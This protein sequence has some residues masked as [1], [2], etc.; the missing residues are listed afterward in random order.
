MPSYMIT[1]TATKSDFIFTLS[2][3]IHLDP[4][5][6][7]EAALL[8]VNLYNSIPNVTGDNNKF[9][10]SNYSGQTRKIITFNK[11]SYEI[12]V[13]ND[14]IQRQMI[15]NGDYDIINEEL[16][17]MVSADIPELKSI[18]N[19]TNQSYLVDFDVEIDAGF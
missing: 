4:N 15:I 17:I 13:I 6:K 16:Y 12:Q 1:H 10:Y 7:Y 14:E 5:K 19:I 3:P 2:P 9:R 18:I 8:S 11:G